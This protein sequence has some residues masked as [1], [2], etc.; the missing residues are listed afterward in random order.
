MNAV[1]KSHAGI[2][3]AVVLLSG[4][5]EEIGLS[6]EVHIDLSE[7]TREGFNSCLE[8]FNTPTGKMILIVS[9]IRSR[10]EERPRINKERFSEI[11][12]EIEEEMG[13]GGL[14]GTVYEEIAL[15]AAERYIEEVR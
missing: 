3:K 13:Y 9:W 11:A 2:K 1:Y 8:P 7:E 4:L 14:V 15:R 10:N 12:L 6:S 5:V